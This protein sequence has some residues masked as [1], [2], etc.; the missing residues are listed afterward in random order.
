M[1]KN[2]IYKYFAL[3]I[4]K[5]F[6]TILFAFSIVAWTVRSVNFLDLIVESGHS[7][8]SYFIY[9]SLN[10]SGVITK[11]I[12][13]SFL[14]ALVVSI[15][16]F[17]KNNE[18]LIIWTAGLNKMKITNLFFLLSLVVVIF[19]LLFSSIITPYTLNKSRDILKNDKLGLFSLNLRENTFT[20]T[21]EG[22]TFFVEKKINNKFYNIF[23][24][25]DQNKFKDILSSKN[26]NSNLTIIAEEGFVDEK[27][28]VLFNGRIQTVSQ[29][30]E[31]NEVIFKK[32]EL[33][34]DNFDTRTTKV[35]KVQE[36]PTEFL[37]QCGQLSILNIGLNKYNCPDN[38]IRIETVSKRLGIPL[39]TP[40]IALICAFLLRSRNKS[41]NNFLKR[42]LVFIVSFLILLF[43]EIMVRFAGFSKINLFIYFFIPI[44][45]I[46][47]L[48]LILNKKLKLQE[49]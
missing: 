10:I 40:L 9:T 41:Q 45:L 7:L 44:I 23:I 17:N 19:H 1:V 37:L 13:I 25:D 49:N 39:Y 29:T 20:D 43:A 16:K 8:K 3:E 46:P 5:S 21:F 33:V 14:L 42:Y 6:L 32:T 15:Y 30:K 34:L 11:F 28:L 18:F 35:P 47:L 4:L 2:K 26:N 36:M 24:S 27:K 12:P 48:Y 22:I 38:N 31:V